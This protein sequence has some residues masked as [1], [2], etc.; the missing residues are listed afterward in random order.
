[1]RLSDHFSNVQISLVK[2]N[3]TS[4]FINLAVNTF[5]CRKYIFMQ[6][7]SKTV[8]K[9]IIVLCFTLQSMRYSY[10]S[11]FLMAVRF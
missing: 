6:R 1:M 7:Y 3:S 10:S 5:L 11:G 9:A 2:N 8:A 4:T